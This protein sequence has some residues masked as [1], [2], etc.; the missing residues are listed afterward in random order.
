MFGTI[1][2]K[3][4]GVLLGIVSLLVIS[5]LSACNVQNETAP[6]G[7]LAPPTGVLVTP[8][9]DQILITWQ[10]NSDNEIGFTV[11]R[12]TLGDGRDVFS[13]RAELPADT[14]RFG[15]TDIQAGTSY[16]YAVAANGDGFRS[17]KI[18]QTG[19]AVTPEPNGAP[20][21]D[22]QVRS[23][24]KG[25]A[26]TLSLSG[27]DPDGDRLSFFI[28]TQPQHGRL[29][30][31]NSL[32][33]VVYT[34][35]TDF[36][37]EDSFRFRVSDG[38]LNSETAEVTVTVL[39][40]GVDNTPPVAEPGRVVTQRGEPKTV[41]LNASDA[42]GDA[43]TYLIVAEPEFGSLELNQLTEGRVVYRPAADF[44]GE[45]NFRFKV[46]DGLDDSNVEAV[47]IRTN[48][49]PSVARELSDQAVYRLD[50]FDLN[51]S[52][53][54]SDA[55]D[56]TLK[57]AAEGL[58]ASL[59]LSEGRLQGRP[60]KDEVG[61]YTVTLTA[62]DGWGGSASTS[63][64]LQVTETC[65]FDG[66]E[67]NFADA[68]L[69]R[70]V[71]AAL[72][73]TTLTCRDMERLTTLIANGS[74]KNKIISLDGLEHARNLTAL[75]LAD[76][77]ISDI[78]AV[79]KLTDL[80]TLNLGG[81]KVVDLTPLT[82]LTQ[83]TG[84]ELLNNQ[85]SD[86]SAL[87]DLTKLTTLTLSENAVEDISTLA[88]LTEL[89]TLWLSSNKV[90]DIGALGSLT[91]LTILRLS[92]NEIDDLTALQRLTKLRKLKLESNQV[93]NLTPLENLIEVRT[94][95]LS[96]NQVRDTNALRYMSRLTELN[97]SSN[98][99]QEIGGLRNLARLTT[100]NLAN[101]KVKDIE[102]L[103]RLFTLE[104]L[105]MSKNFVEGT[106]NL[107]KL[108]ELTELNLS[109]NRVNNTR[110]LDLL[111]KL[112]VLDLGDNV[113]SDIIFLIRNTELGEG[114]TVR[115]YDNSGIPDKQIKAL[116]DKGVAVEIEE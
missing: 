43:L 24:P 49:A 86:V 18:E 14:T 113:I 111:P 38:V 78:S 30:A 28:E 90:S 97:L 29:G 21:A 15:D 57:L 4:V 95:D 92:N 6:P 52:R 25:E 53:T 75:N 51:V 47:K 42:D 99:I 2:R 60:G 103:S 70:K 77:L 74:D 7:I 58:P 110:G 35:D 32:G 91:N 54:F 9:R 66:Y 17:P 46:N 19:D 3:K 109:S 79:G 62:Q 85:V 108:K 5:L 89:T 107:G 50:P 82:R 34:P 72:N 101:N 114:D 22:P 88:G 48:Q 36:T 20:V 76:N 105:L 31:L 23:T 12:D 37:G 65:P 40:A 61:S 39:A 13:K 11:Y 64:A 33:E 69:R 102:P 106:A 100:L 27:A 45:D 26:V 87:A 96:S 41:Q 93:G 112:N 68:N 71:S 115:L 116:T 16:R 84:L 59:Q 55:D 81:N 73:T 104:T 56:D 44:A 63:F 8:Q 1:K 83:L 67:V 80:T 98:D 10:D 94:L